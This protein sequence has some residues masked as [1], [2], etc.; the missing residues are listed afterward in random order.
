MF[1]VCTICACKT[2]QSEKEDFN[3]IGYFSSEDKGLGVELKEDSTFV[4][5]NHNFRTFSK[6][7][8]QTYKNRIILYCLPSENITDHLVNAKFISDTVYYAKVKSEN[9]IVLHKKVLQRQ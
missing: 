8:W 6:G 1:I 3:P 9:K 4:L 5:V 7:K 2:L